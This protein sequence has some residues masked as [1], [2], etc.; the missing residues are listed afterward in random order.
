MNCGFLLSDGVSSTCGI[1]SSQESCNY[2]VFKCPCVT[3]SQIK[4]SCFWRMITGAVFILKGPKPRCVSSLPEDETKHCLW[5]AIRKNREVSS[6][7]VSL[8]QLDNKALALSRLGFPNKRPNGL[9]GPFLL[10]LR[11]N[12]QLPSK[13]SCPHLAPAFW[14]KR[15]ASCFGSVFLLCQLHR[16]LHLARP[17]RRV[18]GLPLFLR[19]P[20]L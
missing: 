2:F 14:V 13:L 15:K 7:S 17:V 10:A 18:T 16:F 19:Y 3:F 12:G 6:F 11:Q 1:C 4:S 8:L 20:E 9:S 5:R